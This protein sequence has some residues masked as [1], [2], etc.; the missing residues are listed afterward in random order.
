MV[1]LTRQCLRIKGFVGG[2]SR[3]LKRLQCRS[4]V[5]KEFVGARLRAH[6]IKDPVFEFVSRMESLVINP[7]DLSPETSLDGLIV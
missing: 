5:K 1:S 3:I 6:T 4:D 2:P 7:N